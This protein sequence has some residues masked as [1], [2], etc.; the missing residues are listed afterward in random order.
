MTTLRNGEGLEDAEVANFHT[1][2]CASVIYSTFIEMSHIVSVNLAFPL[3]Y[4]RI[5]SIATKSFL[6]VLFWGEEEGAL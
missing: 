4:I 6:K 2:S 1:G 3:L 5:D